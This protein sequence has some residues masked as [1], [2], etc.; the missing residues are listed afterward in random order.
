MENCRLNSC[1][2]INYGLYL[3]INLPNRTQLMKNFLVGCFF[4]LPLL[5][6]AQTYTRVN[7]GEII[8]SAAKKFSEEN[9]K[10]AIALY[11]T[12][13]RSDTNYVSSQYQLALSYMLDSNY[14]QALKTCEQALQLN[15]MEHELDLMIIYGSVLDDD[16]KTEHALR[17]YDSAL[18]KYPNSADLRVNRGITLI[19]MEQYNEAE[20]I[21]KKLLLENPFYTSA[22]FRLAQC[23]LFKGQVVPAMYSLFTYLLTNPKGSQSMTAI[24]I[25]DNI[26]KGTED[27]MKYVDDRKQPEESFQATEQIILSKIALDRKYKQLTDLD[28]P[29][30]RQ[31]QVLMEKSKYD[32]AD[33]NFW[34]Q[35]YVPFYQAIYEN[36]YFEPIVVYGFSN[37]NLESIQRYLKRNENAV[38]RAGAF[39]TELLTSIRTTREL[40]ADKRKKAPVL[41][42]FSDGQLYAR[43]TLSEK[44]TLTGK[45]EFYHANGNLKAAG[46][47]NNEG[48]KEGEWKYYYQDGKLSG[49]DHWTNGVQKGEDLIYNRKGI[50][51][52]RSF[53]QNGKLEGKKESFYGIG[54]IFSV[55]NYKADQK[56]GSYAQY[57]SNGIVRIEANYDKDELNG[58]YKSYYRNGA[59][60]TEMLYQ[61]GSL[62]GAYKSYHENGQ[63]SF[64]GTYQNGKLEG[65]ATFYHENG[66]LKKKRK[67]V[68]DLAQ[69]QEEEFNDEGKLVE[70]INYVNGKAEGK[71]E[72]YEDG[73]LFSVLEFEKDVLTRATYFDKAGKETGNAARR[74]KKI[75][76]TVFSADGLP[77]S[78]VTYNDASEKMGDETFYHSNRKVREINSYKGN[79][80]TGTSR[81]YF[82]NGNK[83]F[84]ISYAADEKDGL[85][86]LYHPNGKVKTQGWYSEGAMTDTWITYN[87]KGT[88]ISRAAYVSNDINGIRESY[89]AGGKL[90]E[91]E[92]YELGWLQA[93][94]QYDT[95][96]NRIHTST[97]TNGKGTYKLLHFNGKTRMEG[98]YLNGE[99]EGTYKG[100]YFNGSP[101]YVKTYKK[102]LLDGSYT[103]YHPNGKKIVEGQYKMDQREGKWM[104]YTEEGWKWKE[105]NFV[106]D[107]LTG[108]VYHYYPDGGVEREF[109]YRDN[110]R[111]G[112]T[113]RYSEDGQLVSVFHYRNDVVTG[114]S[115]NGKNGQLV[116]VIALPGGNGKVQTFFS[117]GNKSSE[118]QFEAG[119]LVG[120][121][122]VYHSNGKP[123]YRSPEQYSSTEGTIR[124]Y[125]MNGNIKK[126]LPCADDN[127]HGAYKEY[128][129]S[130][131]VK[132]EGT[133]FNG[134]Q[135]GTV[136]YYNASGK[137][138]EA[139][140][141]YYGL[142]LKITK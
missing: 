109:E 95:L 61:A 94:H 19:R 13:P 129:E 65:P 105:E 140:E 23:A 78:K 76:L 84:E 72:Y 139:R 122:L 58:L 47:Y 26:A 45:W 69:G 55:A 101:F 71:A 77:Y 10:E 18:M 104:F 116:P 12:I 4:V 59:L 111:N 142:L 70:K 89:Y 2:L 132:E 29:I 79:Q 75:D 114:Y 6:Q 16:G 110:V 141:Y 123:Y 49:I 21:F 81:G 25:L 42:H 17:V 48:K 63:L 32:A 22:H 11:K 7:S 52:S 30:I 56:S 68:N 113:K 98:M 91:E 93:V 74:N 120:E 33:P 73:K 37:V 92:V 106:N 62:N 67:F 90:E 100:Y 118:M 125:Y 31:L 60:E 57:Y 131:Q 107:K 40:H 117:N 96:G 130:G 126:E 3:D 41:Y 46:N 136:K 97:F 138:T 137:L 28:D 80:L 39:A 51:T 66:K 54:H 64:T 128:Y 87:E 9:Y 34:M 24:R 86:I 50:L 134:S 102:G 1:F 5:L 82:A 127:Q 85:V 112:I 20:A 108:T 43:G 115:Y 88:L 8:A 133:Y 38:K 124:E 35:Y 103:E 14:A 53:F 135:H 121:M 99:Y 44:E 27:V 36:K 119:Q 15:N 83:E